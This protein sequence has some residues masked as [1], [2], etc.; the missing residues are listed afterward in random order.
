MIPQG[1]GGG[2]QKI[3][4]ITGT[5]SLFL[6]EKFFFSTIKVPNSHQGFCES[7]KKSSAYARRR[8]RKRG[9]GPLKGQIPG[10]RPP[11]LSPVFN[12][13]DAPTAANFALVPPPSYVLQEAKIPNTALP[14]SLQIRTRGKQGGR[15]EIDYPS[16]R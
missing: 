7:R 14:S 13:A 10:G 4:P 8:Q 15:G 1:G 11:S 5:F 3:Y 16:S 9:A 12:Y 6:K 2:K